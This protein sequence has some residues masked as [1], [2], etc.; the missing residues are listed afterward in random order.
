MT[1]YITDNDKSLANR[2]MESV[3][4]NIQDGARSSSTWMRYLMV[5]PLIRSLMTQPQR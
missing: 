3:H 1:L 2:L 5:M 4:L